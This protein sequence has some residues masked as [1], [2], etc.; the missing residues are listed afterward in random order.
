MLVSVTEREA[1]VPAGTAARW[2]S[3]WSET[4]AV[5]AALVLVLQAGAHVLVVPR[6][7]AEDAG[8][9][10]GVVVH[11][12][13]AEAAGGVLLGAHAVARLRGAE[14]ALL[15]GGG[16]AEARVGLGHLARALRRGALLHL[17]LPAAAQALVS[18]R[19]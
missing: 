9:A 11:A 10:L 1:A 5:G 16:G 8:L 14:P 12:L 15:R 4:A 18:L 13:G 19:H 7:A 2:L 17:A 3:E 6:R